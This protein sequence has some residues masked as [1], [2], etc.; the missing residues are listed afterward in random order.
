MIHFLLAFIRIGSLSLQY[1]SPMIA[2]DAFDD[3]IKSVNKESPTSGI[4]KVACPTK[5]DHAQAGAVMPPR[6]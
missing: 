5:S 1:F 4:L 3:G 6:K 2:D